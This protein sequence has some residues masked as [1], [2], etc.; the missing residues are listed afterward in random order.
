MSHPAPPISWHPQEK[1]Q[2]PSSLCGQV[3]EEWERH[4]SWM[5]ALP[6]SVTLLVQKSLRAAGLKKKKKKAD[7]AKNAKRSLELKHLPSFSLTLQDTHSSSPRACQT[8]MAKNTR[9]TPTR[10]QKKRPLNKSGIQ[11]WQEDKVGGGRGIFGVYFLTKE[12]P[13]SSSATDRGS[14]PCNSH[15]PLRHGNRLLLIPGQALGGPPGT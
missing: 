4:N 14:W 15:S 2:K 6:G 8:H 3:F 11:G 12:P 1:P 10:A 13:D 5:A 9:S 7:A